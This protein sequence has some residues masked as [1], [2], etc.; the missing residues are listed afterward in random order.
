MSMELYQFPLSH[1]CEKIR[2]A[3]DCKGVR[4]QAINLIPGLHRRRM[5]RLCGQTAVPV[6]RH[7]GRIICGSSAILDYLDDVAP[8]RPLAVADPL[9]QEQAR[10]WERRLDQQAGPDIQLWCYHH[11]LQAPEL[12]IPLLAGGGP[13]YRR[14]LVRATWQEIESGMRRRMDI[15]P[16][17]AAAAEER[18]L[19][20]LSDL[21]DA[22]NRSHFLVG[23]QLSRVD[24]TACALF[25]MLFRPRAYAVRW[26]ELQC[27]PPA[28]RSWLS[29]HEA[30]LEPLQL[31]YAQYR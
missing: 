14:W 26:P 3:L 27:L 4:Y 8:Q 7:R 19:V 31:R 16:A 1:Y 12:M 30:L 10:Q 20:L 6:L 25:S 18:M 5:Q 23:E 28:M 21:Q 17:A 9:L 22:Y 13:F 24:I 29:R 15:S 2:W 11:L